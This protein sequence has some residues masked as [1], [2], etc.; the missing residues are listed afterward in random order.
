MAWYE[1]ARNRMKNKRIT[2]ADLAEALGVSQGLISHFFTGRREP[3]LEQVGA[4]AKVLGVD[5]EDLFDDPQEFLYIEHHS[6]HRPIEPITTMVPVISWKRAKERCGVVPG[7]FESTTDYVLAPVNIEWG[8]Y[9][10]KVLDDSMLN[11]YGTPTFAPDSVI[12]VNPRV[13]PRPGHFV[14][15]TGGSEGITFRELVQDAGSMLL[16]PLNP[17]YPIVK[18]T[19]GVKLCGVVVGKAYEQLV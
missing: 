1:Q 9:A 15:T 14:I 2:Q 4:I 7:W 3:T 10:L 18:K 11:P 8:A 17:R 12:V 19:K 13:N 5:P 16:K 6:S